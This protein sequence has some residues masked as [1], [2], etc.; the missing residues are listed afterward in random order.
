MC[1]PTCSENNVENLDYQKQFQFQCKI[2][3]IFFALF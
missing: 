2:K 3:M 1:D